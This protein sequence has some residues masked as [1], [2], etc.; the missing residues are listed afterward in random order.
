MKKF[1]L[2]V[3]IPT[4][5]REEKIKRQLHTLISKNIHFRAKIIVVDN[6]SNFDIVDSL[7]NEFGEILRQ[8]IEIVQQPYNLGLGMAITIPFLLCKTEWLWILGDDDDVLGDIDIL[9]D[10]LAKYSGYGML[11]YNIAGVSIHGDRDIREIEEFLNYYGTRKM[12]TGDLVFISNSIFNVRVLGKYLGLAF[13]WSGTLIGHLIP[14]IYGICEREVKCRMI[15]YD[16]V[17]YNYPSK[18]QEHDTVWVTLGISLIGDLQFP[19][20][21]IL[22]KKI[23]QLVQKDVSHLS[24]ISSLMKIKQRERR[25]YIY[26]RIY[27][28]CF[29]LGVYNKSMKILFLFSHF[30]RINVSYFLLGFLDSVFLFIY[31][32][33]P[34]LVRAVRRFLP[35][36]YRSLKF[37]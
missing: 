3:A 32:E 11:K 12:P 7:Q 20:N 29:N 4:Y 37:W 33:M 35:N 2:T 28:S 15:N 1:N 6:H 36:N 9:L 34:F 25:Y 24:I 21:N 16:L 8:Y 27:N 17:R 5:N 10:D 19:V 30:S 31:A 23:Y 14:V 18:D 26:M 22:N 13:E